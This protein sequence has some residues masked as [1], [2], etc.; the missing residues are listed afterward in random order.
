MTTL[1]LE[2]T[3]GVED[4][5]PC[6][7]HTVHR[8][9]SDGCDHALV[10]RRLAC[11]SALTIE[12]R[13][14]IDEAHHEAMEDWTT[15]ATARRCVPTTGPRDAPSRPTATSRTMRPWWSKGGGGRTVRPFG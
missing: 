1:E 3:G 10:G 11:I 2:E 14:P 4:Y 8:R 7:V 12:H 9:L 15:D 13:E 5:D 6:G